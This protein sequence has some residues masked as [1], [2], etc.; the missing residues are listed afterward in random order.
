MTRRGAFGIFSTT[1]FNWTFKNNVSM[2]GSSKGYAMGTSTIHM[3]VAIHIPHYKAQY[4]PQDIHMIVWCF[5]LL[6]FENQFIMDSC[7]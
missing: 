5:D 2:R 6:L 3:H 1:I 4:T 7:D